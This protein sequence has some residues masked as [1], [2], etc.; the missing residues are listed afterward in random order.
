MDWTQIE[1]KWAVMARRIRADVKCGK[2]EESVV[3]RRL[4]GKE[5]VRRSIVAKEIIAGD[6][7]VAQKRDP[8][9]TP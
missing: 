8:L 1:T 7:K 6:A 3:L 4:G 2:I 5:E 9:S